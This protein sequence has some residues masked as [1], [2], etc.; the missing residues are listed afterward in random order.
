[1]AQEK[2]AIQTWRGKREVLV[3]ELVVRKSTGPAK[4][5]S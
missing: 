2:N 3:P 1:M 4:P 5:L